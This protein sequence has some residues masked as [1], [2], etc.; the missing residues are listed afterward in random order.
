MF[1][2]VETKVVKINYLNYAILFKSCKNK[3][4]ELYDIIYLFDMK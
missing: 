4:F 3:L 1:D 2:W